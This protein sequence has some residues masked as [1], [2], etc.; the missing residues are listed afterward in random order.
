MKKRVKKRWNRTCERKK[1]SKT[2]ERF[3]EIYGVNKGKKR[4]DDYR[5]TLRL[6]NSLEGYKKRYGKIE[7]LAKWRQLTRKKIKNSPKKYS[8]ISQNLFYE[9]LNHIDNKDEVYFYEH[10]GEK[11]VLTYRVDFCINKKI[12]EFNGDIWHGNPNIFQEWETPNPLNDKTSKEIW[13]NDKK[14]IDEIK[15]EGFDVKVIWEKDYNE[16][17][18]IVIN[19][20]LQ[21]LGIKNEC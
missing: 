17:P 4:F 13:K 1:N 15:K 6:V 10:N 19:D 5:E 9:L 2:L 21:F 3:K 16:N 18:E 8:K 7:G 12:I 14:R 20:C 11:T